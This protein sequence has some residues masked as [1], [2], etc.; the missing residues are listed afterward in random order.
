MR[1]VPTYSVK[2]NNFFLKLLVFQ[3]YNFRRFFYKKS[4]LSDF[5]AFL[6]EKT[7]E[8]VA[9]KLISR[10]LIAPPFPS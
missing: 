2:L 4:L 10:R 3:E 7:M 1:V 5:N 8:W 6:D 9:R